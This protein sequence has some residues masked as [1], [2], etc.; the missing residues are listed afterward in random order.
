MKRKLALRWFTDCVYEAFQRD[1]WELAHLRDNHKTQS[2]SIFFIFL[3]LT[4][5]LNSLAERGKKSVYFPSSI[6]K[7]AVSFDYDIS[8]F[9]NILSVYANNITSL[10]GS[11]TWSRYNR[12]RLC[13][14]TLYFTSVFLKSWL[15]LFSDLFIAFVNGNKYLML[16]NINKYTVLWSF[17]I[18]YC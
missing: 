5:A 8:L 2:I 18:H 4:L 14:N 1:S 10:I 11:E 7:L 9:Y 16:I 17:I 12:T 15:L 13:L 6:T 3:D